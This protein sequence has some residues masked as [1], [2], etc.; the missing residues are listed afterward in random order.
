MNLTR[1]DLPEPKTRRAL[2]ENAELPAY[3]LAVETEGGLYVIGTSLQLEAGQQ[4]DVLLALRP[5]VADDPEKVNEE[6]D[7]DEMGFLD[8]PL[9]SSLSVI[10][11]FLLFGWGIS[12]LDDE[13]QGIASPFFP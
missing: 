4:R 11:A 2:R 12:E 3:Q 9:F 10:G 5:G 6:D 8:N 13:D 7:D 1:S